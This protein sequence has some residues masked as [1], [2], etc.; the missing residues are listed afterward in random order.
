MD[1]STFSNIG[2]TE[3]VIKAITEMGYEEPT[4]IQTETIPL[5]MQGS[6]VIGLSQTGS[7]KT[8]A[9]GI[10]AIQNINI[11]DRG[12]QVLVLC[13]TRELAVQACDEIR[14]FAKFMHG[15]KT[16]PIYGGQPIDRQI[17]ALKLGAQIVIGTPGR[18]ID[19]IN[20]KTVRLGSIKLVVLDEADEMLNM[21][22]REDI[23]RILQHTTTDR[24]TVLFS[25]TMSKGIL[26]ITHKY[27]KEPQ[28]VNVSKKQMT[29]PSI[30]QYYYDVPRGKKNEA[31][32]RLIDLSN[33]GRSII[34]CNTKK[35]VDELVSYLVDRHYSVQ[36][37]HGDM[38]QQAR[39]LVMAGF[40][41]GSVNVLVATDVA[42]RGIDV[43]DIE[44]VYNYDLP[45][46]IEYYVHR[47]GRTGRAGKDGISHT[48][49]TGRRQ[50][51]FL[52]EIQHF[53][54]SKIVQRAIPSAVEVEGRKTRKFIDQITAIL[55]EKD[56]THELKTVDD[57]LDGGYTS[58][59]VAAALVHYILGDQK[60]QKQYLADEYTEHTAPEAGMS[61]IK[62]HIG[63]ADKIAP[64]HIV[65]AVAGEGGIPGS[66]IGKI[67]IFDHFSIVDVPDGK[68]KQIVAAMKSTK[69]SGKPTKVE[70]L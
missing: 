1:N 32:C 29:V 26:D 65:G 49:M 36:G 54:K 38:K 67:E 50:Q 55:K 40:K 51:L 42:A 23:E 69:I 70:L 35:M 66:D 13:P 22:F 20:R 21:G 15:V 10:P 4:Q 16:I 64:K 56:L 14:K 41:N 24:Q 11:A 37:L 31:L 3:K 34:F 7:G 12:I 48:F 60:P 39:N 17:K 19:H 58:S 33:S 57:L 2:I 30:T 46:D 61:R 52:R 9:F 53:T 44:C 45:Q 47:I 27:Q 8:A 68:A 63:R 43:D 25:A 6:D 5:I 28:I 62:L 18:V 59:E